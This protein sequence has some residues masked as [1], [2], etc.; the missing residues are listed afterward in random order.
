MFGITRNLKGR[1]EPTGTSLPFPGNSKKLKDQ[2][3]VRLVRRWVKGVMGHELDHLSH[4]NFVVGLATESKPSTEIPINLELICIEDMGS[5]YTANMTQL[6]ACLSS[7]SLANKRGSPLSIVT[8]RQHSRHLEDHRD[9]SQGTEF[10][11]PQCNSQS[12]TPSLIYSYESGTSDLFE[13]SHHPHKVPYANTII[14]ASETA[15]LYH[16]ELLLLIDLWLS[17]R[18]AT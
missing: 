18:T 1:L 14:H 9:G 2:N 11:V 16:I 3:V 13:W 4:F 6:G 10:L 8:N 15:E 5:N 7:T 12:N 17:M